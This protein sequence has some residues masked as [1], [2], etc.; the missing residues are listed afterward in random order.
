MK[1]NKLWNNLVCGEYSDAIL[2]VW[3]VLIV[4]G[5]VCMTRVGDFTLGFLAS[6]HGS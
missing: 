2:D 3:G 1:L 6:A 4:R 5:R